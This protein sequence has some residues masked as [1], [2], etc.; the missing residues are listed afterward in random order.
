MIIK[1]LF[2][3]ETSDARSFHFNLDKVTI[4]NLMTT[5]TRQMELAKFL[6]SCEASGRLTEKVLNE[7]ITIQNSRKILESSDFRPLTLFGSNTD[8]IRLVAV[9]LAS[10]PTI[11]VGFELA[12]K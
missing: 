4:D 12:F 2:I 3:S 5:I 8:K 9:V 6:A 7:A 10:G 11:E 1:T